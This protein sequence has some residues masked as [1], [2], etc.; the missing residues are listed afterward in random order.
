MILGTCE[1]DFEDTEGVAAALAREYGG[2]ES[3]AADVGAFMAVQR[4]E[5][6]DVDVSD[7]VKACPVAECDECFSPPA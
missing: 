2:G 5:E 1:L 3:N 6:P 7:C 4:E